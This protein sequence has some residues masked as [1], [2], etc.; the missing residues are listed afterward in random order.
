[1]EKDNFWAPLPPHP[2]PP[3]P[4]PFTPFKFSSLSLG[5]LVSLFSF[6][7]LIGETQFSKFQVIFRVSQSPEVKG[8]GG[9]RGQGKKKS[10]HFYTWFFFKV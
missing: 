4:N 5:K 10:P 2:P 9:G 6:L 1:M 7:F 3:P 8:G